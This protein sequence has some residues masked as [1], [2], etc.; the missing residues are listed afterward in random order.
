MSL[1]THRNSNIEARGER[2]YRLSDQKMAVIS[3]IPF[4]LMFAKL[5]ARE[6]VAFNPKYL[7]VGK[8]LEGHVLDTILDISAETCWNECRN[9]LQCISF[10]YIRRFHLCELN[11]NGGH[12]KLLSDA[13]GYVY[14]NILR[15]VMIFLQ[16]FSFFL[17]KDG[18]TRL[19][20]CICM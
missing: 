2:T 10:N 20:C 6:H 8:K 5:T 7:V 14:G 16:F 9:R 11:S 17:R 12:N 13:L 1:T 15:W 4:L 19:F 3:V 18:V